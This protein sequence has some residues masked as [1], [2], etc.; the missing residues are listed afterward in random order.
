MTGLQPWHNISGLNTGIPWNKGKTN[1]YSK[2]TLDSNRK[3]HLGI[4]PPNK[5]KPMSEEQLIEFLI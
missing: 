4:S 1:I 5:G 3:K 2:E